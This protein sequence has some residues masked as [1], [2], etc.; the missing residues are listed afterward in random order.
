MAKDYDLL[1]IEPTQETFDSYDA[2][3]ARIRH[4]FPEAAKEMT[5]GERS[6]SHADT[7]KSQ[8]ISV[9][10]CESL[11]LIDWKLSLRWHFNF[12]HSV[13][14]ETMAEANPPIATPA[15]S[16]RSFGDVPSGIDNAADFLH[17]CRNN[18]VKDIQH[19]LSSTTD[20]EMVLSEPRRITSHGCSNARPTSNL[21]WAIREAATNCNVEALTVLL[22]CALEQAIDL[23][24]LIGWDIIGRLAI[25]RIARRGDVQVMKAFIEAWP[26]VVNVDVGHGKRPLDGAVRYKQQDMIDLLEDHGARRSATWVAYSRKGRDEWHVNITRENK[27]HLGV[28]LDL[29]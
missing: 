12:N 19:I 21:L 13:L 26:G 16:R 14:Y 2:V 27:R 28:V 23:S 1:Y 8:N 24:R 17:H 10:L 9:S 29:S 25:D 22:N 7:C 3:A 18:N 6:V 15:H 5:R 11:R 4:I 20:L